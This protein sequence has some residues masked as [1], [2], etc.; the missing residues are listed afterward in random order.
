MIL[1]G[2]VKAAL[3]TGPHPPAASQRDLLAADDAG[4]IGLTRQ[5]GASLPSDSRNQDRH[6]VWDKGEKINTLISGRLSRGKYTQLQSQGTF[7]LGE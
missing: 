6:F 7:A 2:Q 5:A 3:T 4:D 1:C